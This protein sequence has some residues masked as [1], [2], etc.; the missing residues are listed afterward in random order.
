MAITKKET[1]RDIHVNGDFNTVNVWETIQII[2][3]GEVISTSDNVRPLN[4]KTSLIDPD[5]GDST[6]SDTDLSNEEE[7]VQAIAAAVW[8]NTIKSEYLEFLENAQ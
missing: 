4:C 3:D 2:E 6:I 8:T 5:T 7:K 1:V